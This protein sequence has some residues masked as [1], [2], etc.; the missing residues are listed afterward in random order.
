MILRL[1]NFKTEISIRIL[2]MAIE[3]KDLHEERKQ[4]AIE[5]HKFPI[6]KLAKIP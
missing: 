6:D 2:M 1:Q 4:A 3:H 5:V